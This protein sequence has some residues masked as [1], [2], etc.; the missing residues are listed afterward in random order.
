MR[1]WKPRLPR[2]RLPRLSKRFLV[3][4]VAVVVPAALA[5]GLIAPTAAH[6]KG[7]AHDSTSITDYVTFYGWVDNSPPGNAI[8]YTG[9][10]T[11]RGANT[12]AGGVGTYSNPV[13]FA[14]PNDLN[15]PW[16][17]I[18]YVPFLKKYFI[19]EDQCDPCGGVNTNHVDLW[20]GGDSKSTSNPEKDA[21]LNCENEWTQDNTVIENPPSNEPVD[22]TALFTPPTTCHGGTGDGGSPGS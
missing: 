16:C 7:K 21:L 17:Q 15:G 3:L 20:M 6:A 19:H 9:C 22:T 4:A 2:P 10:T 1:L 14:E 8:A 18:I 13:T 11:A 5:T 12:T